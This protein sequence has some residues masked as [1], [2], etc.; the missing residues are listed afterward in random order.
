M[1]PSSHTYISTKLTGRTSDLL[2]FGGILPDISSS[3]NGII[4]RHKIHY[5]PNKLYDFIKTKYPD[6]IDLGIGVKLHSYVGKGADYYSDN[7]IT[8]FAILEGK[9]LDADAAKLLKLKKG[10]KSYIL[11]HNFIEA[12]VDL[13]LAD[14]HP[15]LIEM[16][17]KSFKDCNNKRIAEFL[18]SYL[19]IKKDSALKALTKF[20]NR[21][22]PKLIT[23]P[24]K[25]IDTIAYPLIKERFGIVVDKKEA[26]Q[27]LEKAKKIMKGSYL[28]Y[29][30]NATEEMKKDFPEF[31]KN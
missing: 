19:K 7:E 8:G 28:K 15:Q 14:S 9:K 23:H 17:D 6:L 26:I 30:D 18:S 13:N 25:R 29:L 2:V 11:A 3:Y 5:E 27:L 12:G 20:K 10:K 31:V 16:M 1:A 4:N 24:T 22:D 21:F